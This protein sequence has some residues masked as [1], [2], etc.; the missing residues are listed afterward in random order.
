MVQ[1]IEFDFQ[2]TDEKSPKYELKMSGNQSISLLNKD[3][4]YDF[5]KIGFSPLFCKDTNQIMGSSTI[6]Y[7]N[8]KGYVSL[9]MPNLQDE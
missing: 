7:D 3:C 6:F 5:K 2:K 8:E 4:Q 9:E 1:T